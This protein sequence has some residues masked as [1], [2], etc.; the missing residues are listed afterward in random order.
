MIYIDDLVEI[1]N[2]RDGTWTGPYKV[3]D[4]GTR[5]NFFTNGRIDVLYLQPPVTHPDP[6]FIDYPTTHLLARRAERRS[7]GLLAFTYPEYWCRL[8]P[9]K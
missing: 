6:D 3:V 8:A 9:A 5:V 4:R 2:Q 7:D 1:E